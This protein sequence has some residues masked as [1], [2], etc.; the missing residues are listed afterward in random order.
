M[1]NAVWYDPLASV[2][3]MVVV[4]RQGVTFVQDVGTGGETRGM[5]RRSRPMF[6]WYYVVCL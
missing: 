2:V 6:T 5:L 1:E 4:H 3:V